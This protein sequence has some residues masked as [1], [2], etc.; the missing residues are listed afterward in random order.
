MQTMRV[1]CVGHHA[2][3]GSL[4]SIAL[5]NGHLYIPSEGLQVSQSVVGNRAACATLI[6]A[7]GLCEVPLRVRFRFVG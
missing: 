6:M 5:S 2:A 7:K 1:G 3:P 4:L